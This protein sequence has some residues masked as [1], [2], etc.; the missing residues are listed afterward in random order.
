[1]TINY[2]AF[3]SDYR[4]DAPTITDVES[5]HGYAIL[6]FGASWCNHCQVAQPVVQTVLVDYPQ[7][8]C[9]RIADGRGKKL[10][11]IFGVKL[12]PTLVLLKDGVEIARLVRPTNVTEVRNLLA[13]I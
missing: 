1:M 3:N 13:A 11:R 10:G 5:W 6:E 9:I 4:E 8:P 12:W 2:P 7:L